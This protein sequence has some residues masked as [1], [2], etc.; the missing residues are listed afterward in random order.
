[1]VPAAELE[2]ATED[3]VRS[4]VGNAPLPLRRY[5][6]MAMIIPARQGFL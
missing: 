4:I 1:V 2:K 6:E 3:F 5:I